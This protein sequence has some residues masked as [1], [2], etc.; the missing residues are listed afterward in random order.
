M[1]RFIDLTGQIY[2]D[3]EEKSFAFFDTVTDKFC[4]FSGNQYW[5]NIEDFKSDYTG[6]DINR[7]VRLMPPSI[8][9]NWKEPKISLEGKEII[10]RGY[11]DE[12]IKEWNKFHSVFFANAYSQNI[13]HLEK[14]FQIAL[15]NEDFHACE[16][17]KNK[18][19]KL[20]K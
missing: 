18:I 9:H 5:D 19:N 15:A 4:E 1:I 7:F 13:K 3:D 20:K 2:L 16:M 6:D 17:L 8:K 14:E 10:L 11:S 12:R